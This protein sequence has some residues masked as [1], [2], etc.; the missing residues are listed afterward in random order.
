[1]KIDQNSGLLSAAAYLPSPHCNERPADC[2]I[3]TIVIH[4]IS[5]P[6]AQFENGAIAAFF[7]G[8]LD[9]SVHPY[10][11]TIAH[12]HVSAHLLISRTGKI[13]QFVPFPR[14]AWHAGESVFAGRSNCNDFS[15]GIE[16][17]GTDD[18]PYEKI[19]YQRLVEVVRTL[20]NAYPAITRERVVGHSEIAPGRKSDPGASFDWAYFDCLL[21]VCSA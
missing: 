7:T 8:K 2:S 16:L 14:R 15:I 6:P 4:G 12:L 13:T 19:Q 17:E 11:E 5:L 18:L 9:F 1:L 21:A 3:D 20:Q 10:F